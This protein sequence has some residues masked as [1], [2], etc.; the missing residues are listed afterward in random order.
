MSITRIFEKL[1]AP[2]ANSRWSW[3][4]IRPTDGA[5]FIRVWKDQQEKIE[6]AYYMRVTHHEK[7]V[8]KENNLG[9]QE[10]NEHVE[11]IREGAPC[12]MLMC[13]A[14]EVTAVPRAIKCFN[15]KEIFKGGEVIE[16]EG[17]TWV[18]LGE[19]LLINQLIT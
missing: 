15:E 19:R 11:L 14:K 7:F 18:K 5:V 12:F 3:G 17:D 4:S 16:K 13:Q 10:R 1:G 6:N 9:Y 8:G 2:L